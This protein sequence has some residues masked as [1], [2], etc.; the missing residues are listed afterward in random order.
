[1]D[2]LKIITAL[3]E[4]PPPRKHA[5]RLVLLVLG[6]V[7]GLLAGC[8]APGTTAPAPV[9]STHTYAGVSSISESDS[10]VLKLNDTAMSFQY[11]D[12]AAEVNGPG[13]TGA[14]TTDGSYLNLG[15]DSSG[16]PYGMALEIPGEAALVRNGSLTGDMLFFAGTDDCPAAQK[17]TTYLYLAAATSGFSVPQAYGTVQLSGSGSA[18]TISA[19]DAYDINGNSLS[20]PVSSSAVCAQSLL[21][22]PITSPA[23]PTGSAVSGVPG[24]VTLGISPSGYL[25]LAGTIQPDTYILGQV[26]VVQPS[27][28]ITTSSVVAAKYLG[29][30][31]APLEHNTGGAVSQMVSFGQTAGTG[32][33]ITGGEF[34]LDDPTQTPNTD[35]ALNLGTQSAQTN[36]LFPAVTVT[37]PDS[38]NNC[39]G[40]SYGG[41]DASGNPIC[42][43]P[44][45]AIVGNPGGQFVIYVVVS[46]LRSS[47]LIGAPS[48]LG[49]YLY[50]Q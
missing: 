34:L 18:W 11:Y 49:L 25:T 23:S 19:F 46:D 35:I 38:Q 50:Q 44:G 12:V 32:T 1:M 27:S 26:G 24:I 5:S 28:A 41:K 33:T 37:I 21:G 3:S 4:C 20:Y 16:Q 45:V 43:F 48:T 17:N 39:I 15:D 29:F 22:Y 47:A 42:I 31:Y 2:S 14:T 40:Q 9:G 10:Y 7:A 8:S 13:S 30:E 6:A 36:G